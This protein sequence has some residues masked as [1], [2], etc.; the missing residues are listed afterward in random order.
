MG[1]PRMDQE[2]LQALIEVY[3]GR[4]SADLLSII[5]DEAEGQH[6]NVTEAGSLFNEIA[7]P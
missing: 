2:T 6:K 3:K 5:M 1:S 7:R 4:A